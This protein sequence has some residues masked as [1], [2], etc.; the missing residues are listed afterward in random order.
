[1][2]SSF[3]S[4]SLALSSRTPSDS[5]PLPSLVRLS[6]LRRFSRLG[7]RCSRAPTED[8]ACVASCSG[9]NACVHAR[10]HG[11]ARN[12]TR[13]NPARSVRPFCHSA[14]SPRRYQHTGA[15]EGGGGGE[16]GTRARLSHGMPQKPPQEDCHLLIC[17][18]AS[19]R[20]RERPT[21]LVTAFKGNGSL[22]YRCWRSV[23]MLNECTVHPTRCTLACMKEKLHVTIP[24]I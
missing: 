8:H 21:R 4:F 17:R 9:H 10:T 6:T 5:L 13:N 2:S 24:D 11:T 18:R 16:K 19:S 14:K 23:D 7:G 1:M 15:E 20:V 3:P 22:E 12:E